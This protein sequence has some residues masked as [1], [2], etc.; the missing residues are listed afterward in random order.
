MRKF[1]K[2][3]LPL[4]TVA[5]LLLAFLLFQRSPNIE[6]ASQIGGYISG[7]VASLAFI[8]LIAG[9]FQQSNELRLQRKELSMQREALL[10]QKEELKKINKFNALQ[11][12]SSILDSFNS[13][14]PAKQ[15]PNIITVENLPMAFMEG[16][17]EWKI[18]L[19]STNSQEVFDAHNKWLLIESI[20]RQFIST[21]YSAVRLYAETTG[22][23]TLLKN[24]NETQ[25]IYF[26]HEKI[27]GIP[28]LQQYAG[29]AYSVASN[30]VDLGPG[31]KRVAL[32]GFESTEKLMPGVVRQDALEKLRK[33]V[34]DLD[35]KKQGAET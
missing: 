24:D 1:S 14:L 2:N 25:F 31:L 27:K 34:K 17:A 10:L 35:D 23:I 15:I 22:E 12:I 11:Q 26:N 7:I 30:L 9:F 19:E 28:H 29:V 20:C 33:E 5:L 4:T 16:I 6:T 8:W 13:S 18:I 21:F 32:A 3:I